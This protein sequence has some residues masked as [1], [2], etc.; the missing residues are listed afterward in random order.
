MAEFGTGLADHVGGGVG[1]GPFLH[2]GSVG[3][4][5]GGGLAA[6]GEGAGEGEAGEGQEGVCLDCGGVDG[7]LKG[8]DGRGELA[9]IGEGEAE[10]IGG[11]TAAPCAIAVGL[12][13]GDDRGGGGG[14][15]VA[16]GDEGAVGGKGDEGD[17]GHVA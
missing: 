17:L 13:G 9:L 5:G 1:V 7:F 3:G 6:G 2:Q 15:A 12:D 14:L 11:F 10:D 16:E 8:G 4:A